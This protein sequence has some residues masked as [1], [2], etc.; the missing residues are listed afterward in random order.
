MEAE[1]SNTLGRGKYQ[2]FKL[3]LQVKQCNL[4]FRFVNNGPGKLSH[5]EFSF[6]FGL[7]N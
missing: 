7:F 1:I 2:Q 4:Y 6:W 3:I 5:L